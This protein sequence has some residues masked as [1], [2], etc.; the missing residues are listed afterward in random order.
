[1]EYEELL[2]LQ[3]QGKLVSEYDD[4]ALSLMAALEQS[5]IL[6]EERIEELLVKATDWADHFVPALGDV[7]QTKINLTLLDLVYIGLLFHETRDHFI[8]E[9]SRDDRTDGTVRD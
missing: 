7:E 1:M 8:Q 5:G 9:A 3:A 4:T 6:P 2:S